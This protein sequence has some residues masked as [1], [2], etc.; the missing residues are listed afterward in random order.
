MMAMRIYLQMSDIHQVIGPGWSCR[1]LGEIINK[2]QKKKKK[3]FIKTKMQCF[4]HHPTIRLSKVWGGAQ[5]A[6]HRNTIKRKTITI[7]LRKINVILPL[8]YP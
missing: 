5:K 6:Q 7:R 2:L 3:R 4:Y 8:V 1:K